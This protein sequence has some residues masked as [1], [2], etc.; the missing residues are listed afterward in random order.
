MSK[1]HR[2]NSNTY[3]VQDRFS[4]EEMERLL[5][6]DRMFTTAMGGVLPEQ[7]DPTRFQYVLDVGC[8]PGGWLL[9]TAKTYPTM[10]LLVGVDIN[11]K[12]LNHARVQ[13]KALQV[14]DRVEFYNMDG[15]RPLG[16]PAEHFDLVNERFGTSWLRTWEW[17]KFLQECQRVARPGGVIRVTEFNICIESTSPALVQLGE[18]AIKAFYHS[19]HIFTP[20]TDGLVKELPRLMRQY[21]LQD[22]Q[23]HAHVLEYH[24]GT[25]L[26][27]LFVE[28]WT[29]LF[30]VVEP[31]LRKWT[32]VPDSYPDIYQQMLREM[33]QPDFVAV[34]RPVTAWGVRSSYY[35]RSMDRP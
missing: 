17:P 10:S 11:D 6:H 25:P 22:V 9:A 24:A 32:R 30:R 3:T 4:K 18:L 28:D 8:G 19:G 21:G 34:L 20:E 1:P 2:D 15:L 12:M 33:Q 35:V 5:I 26:G 13:A 7:P 16:F 14:D 31:F 29:H 27:Q 23:T